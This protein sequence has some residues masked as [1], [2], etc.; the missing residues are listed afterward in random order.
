MK[1]LFGRLLVLWEGRRPRE[2]IL[3][4]IA[5]GALAVLLLFVGIVLPIQSAS[6]RAEEAAESASRELAMMVRMKREWD[7]LHGRLEQVE[8]RIQ[9]P[10]SQQNLLTLLE[11][12]PPGPA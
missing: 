10:R 8:T 5:G 3:V 4:A 11:A 6:D 1:D 9:Q 2:R 12:S 7:G